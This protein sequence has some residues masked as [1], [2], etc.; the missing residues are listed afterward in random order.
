MVGFLV[1]DVVSGGALRGKGLLVVL[2]ANVLYVFTP[3]NDPSS[4]EAIHHY[5]HKNRL[6]FYVIFFVMERGTV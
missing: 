3:R 1:T 6:I 5:L 2:T 4:I